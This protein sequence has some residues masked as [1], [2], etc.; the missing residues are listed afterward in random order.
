MDDLALSTSYFAGRR[1]TPAAMAAAVRGFGLDRVELGYL[2]RETEVEAWEA[3]VAAE[4]L[5]VVD[6]LNLAHGEKLSL[7]AACQYMSEVGLCARDY[8]NREVN[9]SLSGGELKR[10]EIAMV[11]A[12]GTK[13]S[14]FDE[15]EAG[16]DLW[17]F[18]NLIRVF[19]EMRR[20]IE[21]SIVI[22]SHQERILNIA[23]RIVVI[24]DGRVTEQ[25]TRD[26]VLPKL[27]TSSEA[28][29]TLMDKVV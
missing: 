19:E 23:D 25:G 7:D 27:L 28:C 21:G 16:I 6:L 26:E 22:I 10:I 4:G 9:A 29:S 8:I 2:T 15:P 3:A 1:L 14:I 12:R 18:N 24:A 5:T 20:K 17:S 13:L 11:L